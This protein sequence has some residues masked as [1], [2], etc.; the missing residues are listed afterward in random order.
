MI[1]RHPRLIKFLG[2]PLENL[3]LSYKRQVST[4]PLC[5]MEGGSNLDVVGH[6]VLTMFVTAGPIVLLY[7]DHDRRYRRCLRRNCMWSLGM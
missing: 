3:H 4:T 2:A 5:T 6:Q 1:A 7:D